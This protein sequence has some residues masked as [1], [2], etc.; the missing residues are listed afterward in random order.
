MSYNKTV[1]QL[2]SFFKSLKLFKVSRQTN[3]ILYYA[4]IVT[5]EFKT[6]NK[7]ENHDKESPANILFKLLKEESIIHVLQFV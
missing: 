2:V 4:F 3:V 7:K 6:C 5:C 1:V